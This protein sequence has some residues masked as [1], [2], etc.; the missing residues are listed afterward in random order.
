[1]PDIRT[2]EFDLLGAALTQPI[3]D[4]LYSKV[5]AAREEGAQGVHIVIKHVT[6][7]MFPRLLV[8]HGDLLHRMAIRLDQLERE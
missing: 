3:M 5:Q 7:L 1:M 6:P 8:D 4:Q 2:I